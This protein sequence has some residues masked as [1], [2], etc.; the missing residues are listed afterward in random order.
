M[1]TLKKICA[2]ANDLGL[3]LAIG[4]LLFIAYSLTKLYP[5]AVE[6]A[7]AAILFRTIITD[8]GHI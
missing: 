3:L 5:L 2:R 6:I 1:N 4:A 8:R 7:Q